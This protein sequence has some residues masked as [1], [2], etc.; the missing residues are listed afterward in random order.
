PFGWLVDRSVITLGLPESVHTVCRL[1]LKRLRVILSHS[2]G[3]PT[4]PSLICSTPWSRVL[5]AEVTAMAL[6]VIALRL[7]F[8]FDDLSEYRLAYVAQILKSSETNFANSPKHT[9]PFDWTV[10]AAYAERRFGRSASS[11]AALHTDS[12]ACESEVPLRSNCVRGFDLTL[13]ESASEFLGPYEFKVGESV[14]WGETVMYA[15]KHG[16]AECKLALTEPLHELCA[17]PNKVEIASPTPTSA[18]SSMVSD[19]G[20][21][22]EMCVTQAQKDGFHSPF[23]KATLDFLLHTNTPCSLDLLRTPGEIGLSSTQREALASW[24]VSF[25]ERRSCYVPICAWGSWTGCS[26]GSSETSENK[27]SLAD[28]KSTIPAVVERLIR[29]HDNQLAEFLQL[30]AAENP[31]APHPKNKIGGRFLSCF[32]SLKTTS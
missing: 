24:W 23:R 25:S 18:G 19:N 10:W 8:K 4:G 16:Q 20:P 31:T 27:Y 17:E 14:G 30:S 21:I 12:T 6:V 3:L 32:V 22:P 11:V 26:T 2:T 15:R 29:T 5:R 7:L 9:S 13:L 28:D 1:L